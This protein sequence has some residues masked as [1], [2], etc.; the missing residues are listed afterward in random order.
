MADLIKKDVRYLG[1]DFNSIKANLI[2]F[3]KTYFPNTYQDFNEASP[4]MLFLEMASYV[5]DVLSYYTDVTLQESL[6]TN[7]IERQNV[8]NIA[9]SMGYKP[10]NRV[11][12]VVKLDVFQVIPSI[13]DE[14]P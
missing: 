11:A 1:K 3:S 14:L 9:Q 5:G 2:D 10:K 7:A 8:I 12:A 13:E 4:G 6:I